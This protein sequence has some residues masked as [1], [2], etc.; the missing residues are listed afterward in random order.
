MDESG[1]RMLCGRISHRSPIA[2]GTEA[3]TDAVWTVLTPVPDSDIG[4]RHGSRPD[5]IRTV[6]TPAH[7]SDLGLR[8]G[9]GHRCSA[10]GSHTGPR[11]QLFH[12]SAFIAFSYIYMLFSL[13]ICLFLILLAVFGDFGCSRVG[14]RGLNFRTILNRSFFNI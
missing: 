13:N 1:H 6:L 7:D 9:S 5:A 14:A 4:S 11:Q 3:G 10:G 8:H 12:M 2:Q